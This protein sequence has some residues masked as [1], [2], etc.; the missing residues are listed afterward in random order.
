MPKKG[1]FVLGYRYTLVRLISDDSLRFDKNRYN[2]GTHFTAHTG[3]VTAPASIKRL[4]HPTPIYHRRSFRVSF[5]LSPVEVEDGAKVG[6]A[7]RLH[8]LV[9]LAPRAVAPVEQ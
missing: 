2:A 5:L 8:L 1:V 7:E 9:D 4:S 6:R 3:H